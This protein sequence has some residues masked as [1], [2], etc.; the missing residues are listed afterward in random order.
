M[1]LQPQYEVI[2]LEA[3]LDLV[4]YLAALSFHRSSCM[5]GS[6]NIVNAKSQESC[7]ISLENHCISRSV[8]LS[9]KAA[10]DKIDH[11]SN[12]RL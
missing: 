1:Q 8:S 4:N 5:M 9:C 12:L 7:E 10:Y 11:M 3:N 6:D 2:E